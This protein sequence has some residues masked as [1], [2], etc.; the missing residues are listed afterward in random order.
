MKKTLIVETDFGTFK[1]TTAREYTHIAL[2]FSGKNVQ[3]VT[4]HLS[5]SAAVKAGKSPWY[6]CK[7]ED[8][9]YKIIEV[10]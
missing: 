10:K 3:R 9:I 5:E 1:R 7:A 2:H 6:G 8:K 4:W